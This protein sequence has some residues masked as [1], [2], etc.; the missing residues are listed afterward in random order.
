MLLL[1][2]SL[3]NRAVQGAEFGLSA[4]L[5]DEGYVRESERLCSRQSAS[6]RGLALCRSE[7]AGLFVVM[8]QQHRYHA[9]AATPGTCRDRCAYE[10][11]VRA[12]R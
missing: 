4:E 5:C 2:C 12:G 6:D 10:F 8:A 1:L 9:P 3:V 11:I 7:A